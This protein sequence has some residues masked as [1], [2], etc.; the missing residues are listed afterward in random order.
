MFGY[1]QP[2]TH[3]GFMTTWHVTDRFN[4]YNGAVNGWDRWINQNLRWGYAGGLVWDSPDERT[5]VSV[6]WNVGPNQFPFFFKLNYPNVPNGVPPP[7][8]LSG[9]RN[10]TYNKDDAVL[11]SETVVYEAT[12]DLTLVFESDQGYEPNVPSF[13]PGGTPANAAWFGA[14]GFLLYELTER[15]TAVVRGDVFRDVNGV[16]TGFNDTFNEITLGAIYKPRTWLWI[17]PEVRWDWAIG[18]P[19]YNDETS[20]RQFTYGFDA[21]FLF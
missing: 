18:A 9:R 16:R 1:A 11:F 20:N 12:E 13:G 19:P 15:W 4:L 8:Y 2:Y 21:I 17:R 5:N 3:F 14:G 10:P 7:T 6:S